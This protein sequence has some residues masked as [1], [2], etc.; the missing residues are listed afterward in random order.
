MHVAVGIIRQP[1]GEILIAKRPMDKY[2]GGL[3][4]FP[5]GKV[6]ADETVL[7]A[8]TRE[9]KEEL[10]IEV[11]LAESWLQFEYDYKD[12][13]VLLD[14]WIVTSYS[15]EPQG[16]EGQAIRWVLPHELSQYEFPAGN[17]VILAKLEKGLSS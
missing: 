9:L 10:G 2:K 7:Q 13:I 4:E 11:L 8:L 5:G 6:E 12:R 14:T 17:N 3:W 1:T 16:A 15:G